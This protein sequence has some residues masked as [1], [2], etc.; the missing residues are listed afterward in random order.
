MSFWGFIAITL[1]TAAYIQ[2][3]PGASLSIPKPQ[4]DMSAGD[5]FRWVTLATLGPKNLAA[6]VFVAGMQTWSNEPE[7]YGTHWEG[8]AKRYGA[9]LAAGGTTNT[10]EAVFGSFWGE[11][12]RYYRAAR[13]PL[14]ARLG[15]VVKMAFVTQNKLGEPQLAYARYIAVPGGILVSNTWRPES[16]STVGHVTLRIGLSF[17]SRIV[18]NT[19]SEFMPDL[20][21]RKHNSQGNSQGP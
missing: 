14:K 19:F 21:D 15:H 20:L 17:L 12:P 13:K 5:R 2:G 16:P 6:G 7:T 8:Y 10:L 3:Q 18:G 1:S 11:D 9:R 4:S